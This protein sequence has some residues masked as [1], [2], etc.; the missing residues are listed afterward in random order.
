[1]YLAVCLA[2]NFRLVLV[3]MAY[4]LYVSK[5]FTLLFFTLC[6]ICMCA[7]MKTQTLTS[8]EVSSHTS[9]TYIHRLSFEEIRWG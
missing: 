7:L 2:I 6:G 5:Y 4:L 1:M 8:S 9:H 3:R